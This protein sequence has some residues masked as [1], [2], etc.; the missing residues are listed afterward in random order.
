MVASHVNDPP[1]PSSEELGDPL[2]CLKSTS[3]TK[4]IAVIAISLLCW[5][6]TWQLGVINGLTFVADSINNRIRQISKHGVVSQAVG[7]G[8]LG[9]G[10]EDGELPTNTTMNTPSGVALSHSTASFGG[11]LIWT[12]STNHRIRIWNRSTSAQTLFG[13]SV[14]AGR[15]ATIGG[16]SALGNLTTGPALA[17][18][19]N[20]P[21]GLAWNP[22]TG[23]L[24]VSDMTNHCVKAIDSA[25]QLSIAA[26]SCGSAGNVDGPPGSGR[27]NS[28]QGLTFYRG[29]ATDGLFIADRGNSRVRF[30]RTAGSGIFAGTTVALGD[31]NSVAGGGTFYN[32]GISASLALIG[33]VYG[34]AVT[35]TKFCFSSY[36]FHNVRCVDLS[37]GA[38]QTVMGPRVGTDDTTPEW[39][40]GT[41]LSATGQNGVSAYSADGSGGLLL[42]PYGLTTVDDSTLLVN[43]YQSSLVR[44]IKF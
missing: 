41:S 24:Y 18:A 39:F 19:F 26:G 36:S 30:L 13:V 8:V 31:A 20:L 44:K 25:G 1:T 9:T 10:M 5:G 22:T 12:D 11:H 16:G 17:N 14:A 33:Q 43:E 23:A 27:L 29:G 42:F 35:A 2:G 7:T 6:A 34:V 21:S 15:V 32:E 28:P 4:Q 40:G 38:I 37:S 3:E